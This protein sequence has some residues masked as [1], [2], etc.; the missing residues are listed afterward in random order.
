MTKMNK[1]SNLPK[2]ENYVGWFYALL[3]IILFFVSWFAFNRIVDWFDSH[4]IIKNRIVSMQF[5]WPISIEKR[6]PQIIERAIEPY[7]EELID[8]PIKKYIAEKFGPYDAKI[9]LS[10]VA[11]ESNFNAEAWNINSNGTI[12]IGIWQINSVHFS[13]ESCSIRDALDPIRATDC[14]YRI[15]KESGWQPW[16]VFNNGAYLAKLE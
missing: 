5:K 1:I 4:Q 13:K 7:P 10:I 6:E 11:S 9:A 3:L 12:D 15:F 14:A 2:K 16:T 8:T